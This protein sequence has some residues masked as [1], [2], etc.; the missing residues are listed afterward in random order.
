MDIRD[1]SIPGSD[2]QPIWGNTH[3]PASDGKPI[4]VMVLC[5][6]FKGYK[7]YGFVP[8]LAQSAADRGLIAH[9]FNFSHSGMTPKIETFER[10]DLFERDTWSRQIH[11][12]RAVIEADASG[13]LPGGQVNGTLPLVVY[14]H[15]RGGVTAL[16]TTAL[17]YADSAAPPA[18]Q[19]LG[20]IAAS[21]PDSSCRLH[22]DDIHRLRQRG[23]LETPSSRT[24]QVLRIGKDWLEDWEQN[25]NQYDPLDAVKRIGCPVL[26]VHGQDDA[27]VD[28]QASLNLAAAAGERAVV[29]LIPQ[30]SH[31][32]NC[33]NPLP[34]GD[35]PPPPTRRMVDVS[36]DFAADLCC[37]SGAEITGGSSPSR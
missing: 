30:A 29:E 18:R 20:V 16:M 24:G 3:L 5:H 10:P 2:G 9:R 19:P 32:F 31:T 37:G 4:G 14:G 34:L 21:A 1:W 23:Y 13:V 12:L 7:D 26:L 35:P 6:G 25:R 33:P 27:T 28:V 22:E 17:L 8:L 11:D 15:S 36:C